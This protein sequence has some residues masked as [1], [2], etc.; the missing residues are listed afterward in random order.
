VATE[1]FISHRTRRAFRQAQAALE[2]GDFPELK[3]QAERCVEGAPLVEDGWMMLAEAYAELGLNQPGIEWMDRGLV[4]FPGNTHFEIQRCKFLMGLGRRRECLDQVNT[5][6]S[7]NDLDA[8]SLSLLGMLLNMLDEVAASLPLYH[9]LCEL[10]PDNAQNWLDLA[11]VE[12]SAGQL[13]R[14]RAHTEKALSLRPRF[15]RAL[16]CLSS[17]RTATGDDQSVE[18]LNRLLD[19]NQPPM[20][21]AYLGYALGKEY[22]DLGQWDLAYGALVDAGRA[23]S[24]LIA[25]DHQGASELVDSLIEHCDEAFMSRGEDGH[26]SREPIFVLGMPRTGTTLVERILGAHDQVFAGGELR[27]FPLALGTA[28]GLAAGG[29]IGAA[30]I[31][32]CGALDFSD[33]GRNY[34]ASTRPR[35]G[36]TPRFTDKLP[37]NFLY[38]GLIARALPQASIIHV[39]RN[40]MDTCWSNFKVLFGDLYEYSYNLESIARYFVLYDRLMQHWDHVLPGRIVH[41]QYESLVTDPA[42]ET[43]RLLESCGLPWQETC[44]DHHLNQDTVTTASTVQVRQPIYQ[45]ALA[46]WKHYEQHLGPVMSI[47]DDA[48]IAY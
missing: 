23:R 10:E 48:G 22:E 36:H 2:A 5:L 9:R 8:W 31:R 42:S 11:M 14:A 45:S 41:V 15:P 37:P 40:P 32:R 18:T 20:D 3:T 25:H 34:I 38:L 30:E 12:R 13:E 33:L 7:R 17:L 27:Q 1:P 24:R 43:R 26:E 16:W 44:L 21:R 35:T 39:R 47:L 29:R 6:V 19:G 4:I 28:L 46:H